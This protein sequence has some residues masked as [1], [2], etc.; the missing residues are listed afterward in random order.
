M[1]LHQLYKNILTYT[2]TE[3][4]SFILNYTN[5]RKDQLLTSIPAPAPAKRTSKAKRDATIA[6]TPEQLAVLRKLKLI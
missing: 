5:K 3:L 1:K 6:V 4:S 2:Q